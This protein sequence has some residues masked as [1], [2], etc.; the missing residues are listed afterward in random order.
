MAEKN[1]LQGKKILIVDDELDVLET[2]EELLSMCEL[3]RASSFD[4]AKER[5]MSGSFDM[6]ILDIM[7]V[8]GYGLLEIASENNL[9]AVMLT[10]HALTIEDTIKS[11]KK[12]AAFF[13]SKRKDSPNRIRIGRRFGSQ[14]KE[15]KSLVQLAGP[16]GR[17]L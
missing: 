5:M 2:L 15:R 12:G 11:Y 1:P 10:A 9:V 4:Q 16:N 13:C 6:V 8:N 7:G 17:L 3:V 14:K